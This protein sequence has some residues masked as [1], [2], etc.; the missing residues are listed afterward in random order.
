MEL[1]IMVLLRYTLVSSIMVW[2]G[3]LWYKM[4]WLRC[5]VGWY[6]SLL[7]IYYGISWYVMVYYYG[8]LG[9]LLCIIMIYYGIL[10][11][12]IL[13]LHIMLYHDRYFLF[14]FPVYCKPVYLHTCIFAHILSCY[15]WVTATYTYTYAHG[16]TIPLL[17]S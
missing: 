7:I 13:I 8:I 9:N 2:L 15:L 4:F 12:Y 5:G 16:P 6:H 1:Y 11:W 10:L 3:M 17:L 14:L